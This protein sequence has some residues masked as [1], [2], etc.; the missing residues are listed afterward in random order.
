MVGGSSRISLPQKCILNMG[1]H[2]DQAQGTDS[3]LVALVHSQR[4]SCVMAVTTQP[5]HIIATAMTAIRP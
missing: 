3:L 2:H 5:I 1:K 4:H